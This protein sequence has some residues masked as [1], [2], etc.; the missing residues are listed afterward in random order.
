[1]PK[2]V[3]DDS[4]TTISSI[5]GVP[6][7]KHPRVESDAA[8]EQPPSGIVRR[9]A[10]TTGRLDSPLYISDSDDETSLPSSPS[11]GGG[12]QK[13]DISTREVSASQVEAANINHSVGQDRESEAVCSTCHVSSIYVGST[14][15]EES[16]GPEASQET[17]EDHDGLAKISKRINREL[18][19]NQSRQDALKDEIERSEAKA[20]RLRSEAKQMRKVSE[21][22]ERIRKQT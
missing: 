14:E 15:K 9:L 17:Y 19:K 16:S 10:A 13:E 7:S 5:E 20:Q 21:Y 12:S 4:Y 8:S 2:R 11:I 22:L 1:M 3:R 18:Q 6:Q